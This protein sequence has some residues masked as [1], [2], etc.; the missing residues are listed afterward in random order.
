MRHIGM[1]A[2][3]ENFQSN[4]FWQA[5]YSNPGKYIFE[6]EV[7]FTLQH[8]HQIKSN[9]VENKVNICDFSFL[10]DIA[11]A[12]V[13]LK[14]SQLDAY[15]NVYKEIERELPPP[16][17][18]VYL[19]CDAETELERI[20][21]R[22]RSVEDPITLEFLDSLNKAVAKEVDNIKDQLNVITL[23]SAKKNFADDETTK[24]EMLDLVSSYL[25][26]SSEA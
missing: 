14:E 18:I 22:G 3:F 6:T 13:G 10:L 19:E 26:K 2:L 15:L 11:Y 20:R 4:P 25:N 7:T 24:Q 5:F 16:S 12:K 1:E 9:H 23:D 21:R 17:L 8:Y